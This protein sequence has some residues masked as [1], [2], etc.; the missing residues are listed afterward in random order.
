MNLKNI[1]YR[2]IFIICFLIVWNLLDYVYA[3]FLTHGSY[4][5]SVTSN[6]LVPL[7]MMILLQAVD[8]GRKKK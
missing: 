4:Q 7:G 2:L 6:M 5:F 1:L 3:T 8:T